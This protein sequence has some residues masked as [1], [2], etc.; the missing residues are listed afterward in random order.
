[1]SRQTKNLS[2]SVIRAIL[3]MKMALQTGFVCLANYRLTF[4]M[5]HVQ[6]GHLVKSADVPPLLVY[7]YAVGGATVYMVTELQIASKFF[8]KGGVAERPPWALWNP[9]DT[10]FGRFDFR[11]SARPQIYS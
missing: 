8:G 2:A 11:A 9:E 4:H 5:S 3:G 6:V 7:D 1:V 10:L